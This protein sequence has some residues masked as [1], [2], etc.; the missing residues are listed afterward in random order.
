MILT[1]V[2]F[3]ILVATVI[4]KQ[5]AYTVTG[6]LQCNGNPATNQLIEMKFTDPLLKG[7]VT[8]STSADNKGAFKINGSQKARAGQT[9]Y[10]WVEHNCDSKNRN[11]CH[12]MTFIS[13]PKKYVG[14][15]YNI[16]MYEL[17]KHVYYNTCDDEDL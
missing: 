15:Q 2:V 16:G 12:V 9:A 8:A 10:L 13:I 17:S 14:K 6:V 4:P 1:C 5:Q 3:S 11:N 7:K